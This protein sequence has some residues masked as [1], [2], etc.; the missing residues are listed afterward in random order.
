MRFDG[1]YKLEDGLGTEV[2]ATAE[3]RGDKIVI[4]AKGGKAGLQG[5]YIN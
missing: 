2:T 5:M 3:D 4:E 1:E